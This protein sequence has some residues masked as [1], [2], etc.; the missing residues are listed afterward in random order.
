MSAD[1]AL[2]ESYHVDLQD[3]T[4]NAEGGAEK[5]AGKLIFFPAHRRYAL[6]TPREDLA[7][8]PS[9]DSPSEDLE[10]AISPRPGLPEG[11]DMNKTPYAIERAMQSG[12]Y[13]E[14]DSDSING[15]YQDRLIIGR[16]TP[17]NGGVY[18][19]AGQ[20]EAI[21]V[22]DSKSIYL[23][24]IYRNFMAETAD[25]QKTLHFRAGILG[26]IYDKVREVLPADQVLAERLAGP[27]QNDRKLSLDVFIGGKAGVCRH[28]ALLTGYLL[29]RLIKEGY[30]GGKVSVDRNSIKG[31]GGHAWVRYVD[32]NGLVSIVDPTQ[33]YIGKLFAVDPS[34]RWFYK[35]PEDLQ[36][37]K[38]RQ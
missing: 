11:V 27:Y 7:K 14:P 2:A 34:Q 33:G 38:L 26:F 36:T 30:I 4:S 29:E 16:D 20:R 10:N 13:D 5:P 28:Q 31:K 12:Y 17:I 22:D 9:K 25:I 24:K 32:E 15:Y 19:G 21:V 8:E 18:L 3:Q 37:P 35:R 6:A 1:A 23:D